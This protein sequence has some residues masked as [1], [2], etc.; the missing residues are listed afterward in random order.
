MLSIVDGTSICK[1]KHLQEGFKKEHNG[2]MQGKSLALRMETTPLSAS[3]LAD[4]GRILSPK[5]AETI[6]GLSETT[7]WRLRKARDFPEAVPLSPR[8]I[9]YR[10]GDLAEWLEA[11]GQAAA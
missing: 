7:I 10:A 8:R 9:G 4:P 2:T 5:M 6:T 11:R 3:L 1:R